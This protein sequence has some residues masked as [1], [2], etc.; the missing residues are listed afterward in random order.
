[1]ARRRNLHI[2]LLK[3]DNFIQRL[4]WKYNIICP[5]K[6]FHFLRK[7]YR[8]LELLKLKWKLF[9]NVFLNLIEFFRSFKL[10]ND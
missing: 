9:I 8:T 10:L 5:L 6:L 1:M 3:M 2:F 7:N 4:G